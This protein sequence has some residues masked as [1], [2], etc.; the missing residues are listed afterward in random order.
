M[1]KRQ[2]I[3]FVISVVLIFSQFTNLYAD[4]YYNNFKDK[5]EYMGTWI[6]NTEF[7]IDSKN[8]ILENLKKLNINEVYLY[9]N[10]SVSVMHYQDFIEAA[11]GQGINVHALGGSQTWLVDKDRKDLNSF[12]QWVFKYNDD[13]KKKIR[14]LKEFIL[15]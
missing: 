6:W 4:S 13:A 3:L 14:D 12:L 5:D 9:I 15:T 1:I 11:T 7:I 8:E 2:L 10:K